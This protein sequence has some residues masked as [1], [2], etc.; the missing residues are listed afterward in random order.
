[1]EFKILAINPGSTSTKVALYQDEAEL[2][3]ETLDHPREE[4]APYGKVREQFAMRK[5]VVLACLSKHGVEAGQLSAVVGRGGMLPAVKSGA[6][7]VN[8]EMLD[9]LTN[10]PVMEHA[11]NLGALLA[12][13]IAGLAG[14]PAYIYDSVR[15]DELKPI[16]R[17]SGMPEIPRTSTSHA[18]NTRAMAIKYAYEQ[19]REYTDMNFI[20][21]HL[22]GGI[23]L[24]VHE[25]GQLVD[26]IPDD[27]GPFS[28]EGS[29]RVHC[30]SLIKLC[31]A[32]RYDEQTMQKKLRGNGGLKA[33]LQ[34]TDARE[35]EAM[36]LA[37]NEEARL[38]YE[39]MA[40]QVAKGI[41]ELATVVCGKLDAIIITGGIAYSELLTSWIKKRVE[42]LAP[43]IVMSGENEMEALALGTLRVLRGEEQARVYSE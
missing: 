37:G 20:V 8:Q 39:A 10:H 23:S 13:E 25:K 27:E 9:A 36:I 24:N 33:Y 31:Y 30:K 11:S 14:I 7:Q 3:C 6:Y 19:G 17:L 28:P 22:G 32:D 15:V 29:G 26:V 12:Y 4:M 5:A 16:A 40:Y 18:L 41:G 21:A 2:F 1:M 43:V 38:V 42:F 34:T 35:V